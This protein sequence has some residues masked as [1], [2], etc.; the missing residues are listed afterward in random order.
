M[1]ID[2]VQINSVLKTYQSLDE[3]CGFAKIY[4]F[5]CGTEDSTFYLT[6]KR[7]KFENLLDQNGENLWLF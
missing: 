2:V 3:F 4:C 5:Y 6:R 1:K 7:I